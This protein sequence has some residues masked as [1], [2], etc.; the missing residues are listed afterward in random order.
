MEDEDFLA[1]IEAD[2]A[3]APV[4]DQ[5]K[6]ETPEAPKQEEQAEPVADQPIEAPILTEPATPTEPSLTVEAPKPEPGFVPFAA[7]LDERD[8]RKAL[9]AQVAQFQAQQAQ[10]QQPF[11]M[12]DPVED[13]DGFRHYQQ[14]AISEGIRQTNLNWS[15]RIATMEHGPEVVEKAYDWAFQRCAQ[16]PLFNAKVMQSPDPVGLAVAE[17]NREQIASKVTP[18]D[19][20]EFKAWKAAQT[21]LQQQA[22][23]PPGAAAPP[24]PTPTLPPK[25]LA[26]AAS[27]GSINAQVELSEQ[28]IFEGVI[29]KG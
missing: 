19:F 27:A 18:Q 2:N 20:D 22:A 21:T 12:P 3:S 26:S 5:P 8:K 23:Q 9:E 15:K 1:A 7:V 4:E 11:E 13:P 16:D 14:A 25:S 28:D 24:N 6:E 10:N 17:Y 29:P